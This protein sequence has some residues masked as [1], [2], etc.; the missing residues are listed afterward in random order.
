MNQDNWSPWQASHLIQLT[1]VRPALIAPVSIRESQKPDP[2][3][4][5]LKT[6]EVSTITFWYGY[7]QSTLLLLSDPASST[8]STKWCGK[9]SFFFFWKCSSFRWENGSNWFHCIFFFYLFW[10]ILLCVSLSKRYAASPYSYAV[11]ELQSLQE[12][13]VSPNATQ[14]S[15]WPICSTHPGSCWPLSGDPDTWRDLSSWGISWKMQLNREKTSSGNWLW[16]LFHKLNTIESGNVKMF[17]LNKK[18]DIPDSFGVLFPRK[19]K[20]LNFL[21]FWDENK[22]NLYKFLIRQ[23]LVF[24]H[25]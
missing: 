20:K 5:M 23:I 12:D 24:I 15:W 22:W 14:M 13:H 10:N 1:P 21:C 25:L 11:L 3:I 8:V 9:P 18:K 7:R 17:H 2:W 19:I 4:Q 6:K 16:S